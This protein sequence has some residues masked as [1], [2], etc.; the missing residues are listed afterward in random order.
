[1][2]TTTRKTNASA[3]SAFAKTAIKKKRKDVLERV[4]TAL[5]SGLLHSSNALKTD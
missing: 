3:S 2:G 5:K 1:M 4:H